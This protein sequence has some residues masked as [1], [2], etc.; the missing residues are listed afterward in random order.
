MAGDYKVFA[1]LIGPDGKRLSLTPEIAE[2]GF[3]IFDVKDA[4]AGNWKVLTEYSTP[5][6]LKTTV[7]VIDRNPGV[8]AV[9]DIPA[10]SKAGEP[11]AFDIKAY[12]DGSA[13][14]DIIVG[15][16]MTQPVI[17]V[18]E[19]LVKYEKDLD[20]INITPDTD[21][22]NIPLA[23]LRQLKADNPSIEV[24]ERRE[25]RKFLSSAGSGRF[26]LS[27]DDTAQAGI[28]TVEAVI[29]GT[30]KKTG[31]KFRQMKSRAVVVE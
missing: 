10:T 27:T 26:T 17:S 18:D 4:P 12:E 2:G 6:A 20:K 30:E 5:N 16:H 1:A 14:E 24:F 9:L 22:Q 28:Y 11:L 19:A 21:E 31:L 25:S 15:V 3:C 23:K 29:E 8:N 7:G 13:L